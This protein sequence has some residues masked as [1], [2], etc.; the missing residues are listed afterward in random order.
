[1]IHCIAVRGDTAASALAMR[2]AALPSAAGSICPAR[3]YCSKASRAASRV[4][5]GEA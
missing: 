4:A 5:R 3:A 1:M 2:G